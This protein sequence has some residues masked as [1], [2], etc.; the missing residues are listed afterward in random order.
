MKSFEE[1]C[2]E[3]YGRIYKYI[4]AM[5]GI[6]ESAQDLVQDVFTAAFMKGD[7]FMR[8][9][10]PTAFLYKTARNLTL[11]Y[12]KR[13]QRQSSE[14]IDEDIPDGE[15]DLCDKLL[16]DYDRQVD[17]AAYAGQVI[18]LLDLKQRD[19]YTERYV[20]RRPIRDIAAGQDVSE[21]AV[22]M[23]LVRLRREIL[24]IVKDLKLD[25]TQVT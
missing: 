13:Q 9:E 15:D 3:N 17:E 19:L 14:P 12:L 6:R 10:N 16:R 24:R 22:R 18:S 1:L 23:R 4:F 2:A 21:T 8:H 11:T 20:A 25:E 7:G 5:T